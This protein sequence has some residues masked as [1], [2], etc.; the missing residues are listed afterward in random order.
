[1]ELTIPFIPEDFEPG[2]RVYFAYW[3]SSYTKGTVE[4]VDGNDIHVIM[5]DN[6]EGII[7][8]DSFITLSNG[9][10]EYW[11]KMPNVKLFEKGMVL[12]R[13]DPDGERR[14]VTIASYVYNEELTVTYG[15]D[16]AGTRTFKTSEGDDFEVIFRA[17]E[18]EG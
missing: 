3:P 6:Q 1:M 9:K 2:D 8:L 16:G 12:S 10:N 14:F 11:G 17:W 15:T 5:D 4:S 13:P 18:I 7:P